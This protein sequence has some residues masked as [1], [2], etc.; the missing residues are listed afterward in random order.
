MKKRVDL[1]E[2]DIND[3]IAGTTLQEIANPAIMYLVIRSR[4]K[5]ARQEERI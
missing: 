4:V 3:Y 2:Q 5:C 1:T